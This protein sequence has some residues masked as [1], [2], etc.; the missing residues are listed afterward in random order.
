LAISLSNDSDLIPANAEGVVDT[1]TAL[2][3]AKTT[4][5]AFINGVAAN[6][7]PTCVVKA[8]GTTITSGY[9]Y[10]NGEFQL[11]SWQNEVKNA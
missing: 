7:F 1:A 10:S 2:G 5:K 6:S 11:T 3:G 9:T 4:V 8:N